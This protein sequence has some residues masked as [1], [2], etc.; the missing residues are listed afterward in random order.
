MEEYLFA[1]PNFWGLL[2]QKV[3]VLRWA[4]KEISNT[5]SWNN[6]IVGLVSFPWGVCCKS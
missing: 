5:F 3:P 4:P 6:Q 1:Q 2:S